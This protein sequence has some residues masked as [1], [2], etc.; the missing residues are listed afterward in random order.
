M[1]ETPK[2]QS[3]TKGR[4]SRRFAKRCEVTGEKVAQVFPEF[5]DLEQGDKNLLDLQAIVNACGDPTL[6]SIGDAVVG[7]VQWRAATEVTWKYLQGT[8]LPNSSYHAH[9]QKIG[10]RQQVLVSHVDTVTYHNSLRHSD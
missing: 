9:T 3:D 1:A 8:L 10:P 6:T 7:R 5:L 4:K 2:K